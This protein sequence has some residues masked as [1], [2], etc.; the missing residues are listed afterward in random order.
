VEVFRSF[1][2]LQRLRKF[3]E[4]L[5]SDPVSLVFL[6]SCGQGKRREG[7][8]IR[9][10]IT[11]SFAVEIFCYPAQSE[12]TNFGRQLFVYLLNSFGICACIRKKLLTIRYPLG[13]YNL[14]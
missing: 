2:Q 1:V 11:V 4:D 10:C 9:S 7:V 8:A 5:R 6:A 14:T 13:L 12:G 3:F